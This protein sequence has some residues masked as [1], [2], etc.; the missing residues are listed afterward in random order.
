LNGPRGG[1]GESIEK[2]GE[3]VGRGGFFNIY[4]NTL[5]SKYFAGSQN[6]KEVQ[7]GFFYD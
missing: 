4:T 3:G 5:Q 6:K 1:G 7:N 2:E